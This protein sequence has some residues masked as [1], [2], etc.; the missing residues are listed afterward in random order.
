MLAKILVRSRNVESIE[1]ALCCSCSKTCLTN[2]ALIRFQPNISV[3][4]T[5]VYV[6]KF[7]RVQKCVD[8]IE[9][10]KR[11]FSF[12]SPF[13][14]VLQSFL[15][16]YTNCW[17]EPKD[18]WFFCGYCL[19]FSIISYKSF[20]RFCN[21]VSLETICVSYAQHKWWYSAHS[22][23]SR[24]DIVLKRNIRCHLVV[25]SSADEGLG[26]SK[27]SLIVFFMHFCCERQSW[28]LENIWPLSSWAAGRTRASWNNVHLVIK[29]F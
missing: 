25:T 3:S 23:S 11:I 14:I 1:I 6:E 10:A 5:D 15:F 9:V 26:F 28:I 22:A 27:K 7:W 18:L 17:R 16:R 21:I 19:K 29:A 20:K 4:V 13:Y 8:Y 12:G 24:S 2:T